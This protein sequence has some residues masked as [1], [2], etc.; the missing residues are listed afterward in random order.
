MLNLA[1]Y[2]PLGLLLGAWGRGRQR[3]WRVL[4]LIGLVL[5]VSAGFETLQFVVPDRHPSTTD[6]LLNTTGGA[7]G[8]LLAWS[9]KALPAAG[10]IRRLARRAAGGSAAPGA[11]SSSRPQAIIALNRA[12]SWR[13]SAIEVL[14][15]LRSRRPPSPAT[16][17]R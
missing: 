7:I 13:A 10:A 17:P 3:G 5:V 14:G 4:W 1:G 6:L 8:V 16:R 12:R 11:L 2:L 15:R 9:P